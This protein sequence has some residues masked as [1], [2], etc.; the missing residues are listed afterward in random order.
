L[1]LATLSFWLGRYRDAWDGYGAARRVFQQ[2]GNEMEAAVVD[3]YLSRVYLSLN[4]YPEALD[5]ARGARAVFAQQDM[6]R[7]VALADFSQAAACRGLGEDERAQGLFQQARA[8]F[9]AHQGHTWAALID[10]ERTALLRQAGRA[11][12]A[13]P[14]VEGAAAVFAQHGLLVRWDQARLLLAECYS[15]LGQ[16]ERARPLYEA[17][18][19]APPEQR[20]P[21]LDY[22]AYYG[23]GRA[24]Q[25]R[26]KPQ[27]AYRHYQ[28]AIEELE[29]IRRGL[30]VDEFKA[31]FLDDKLA[32]YQA[33]VR[34]SLETGRLEAA[35]DYVERSKSSALLDLLARDPD[36]W[37]AGGETVDPGTWERLRALKEE[38]LWHHA[39]LQGPPVEDQ[40]DSSR[41]E[42]GDSRSWGALRQVE[43]QLSQVWRQLQG[44]EYGSLAGDEARSWRAVGSRLQEGALLLEYF[45]IGDEILAFLLDADG[46]RV[47]QDFPYSLRE[48]RRSLGALELALK[49]IGGLD[50]AYVNEVLAPLA[51]RHLA[52]LYTA[53]VAPLAACIADY[54]K[55]VIVPH[56][57]LYYLPF[58]ALHHGENYLVE[59][60][61]VQ[62]APSASVL[63]RC[64]QV[65]GAVAALDEARPALVMG[66]SDGGRLRYVR[67][68]VRAV[69]GVLERGSVELTDLVFEEG[70]ATLARLRQWAGGCR[71]LHLASHGVFRSDNPLFSSIKLADEPLNVIDFYHLRLSASLVTLSAC[72]TGLSQLK[73]GDLFGLARGC[74]YAGAPALVASLW[75]VDD[76]STALLMGE[77][78]RRLEAGERVASALRAAQRQLRQID[79]Y[80][81]PHYWAPFFLVGA[82]G[83]LQ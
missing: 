42:A 1:N 25:A 35:F 73:G 55:L 15:D 29:T 47:H 11:A 31:S 22:R 44:H 67:D 50:P 2:L 30:R 19:G 53:L 18:L 66:Y 40:D 39:K 76:A 17:V 37:D 28:A 16:V 57:I 43:S 56:D 46:L 80:E 27:V 12:Q 3:L 49:G 69:A 82:D 33:A 65:Q 34:L 45:C 6:A 13:L 9:D 48:V 23:L 71:L 26:G 78:Y 81:H 83:V 58:H 70:E 8:F 72:E 60:F 77:F 54:S 51:Q 20:L 79:R 64:Y 74:L 62:Y 63:E 38:W 59:R 14:L 10:L 52:W 21:T 7:Y 36:L 5:L 32:L 75:Q 61:E 24:E 41:A 68:E 4:L